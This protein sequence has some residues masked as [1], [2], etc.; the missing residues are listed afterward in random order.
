M[1]VSLRRIVPLL[2]VMVLIFASAA[3]GQVVSGSGDFDPEN[4]E[5]LP[6]QRPIWE[7]ISAGVFLA[8]AMALGFKPSKRTAG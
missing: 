4:I 2:T 7:Y 5:K 6:F 3:V 1:L 8:V